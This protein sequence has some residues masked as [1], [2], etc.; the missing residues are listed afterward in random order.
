MNPLN[1]NINNRTQ[2]GFENLPP[3][4]TLVKTLLYEGYSLFP[5]HRSSIKNLKPIPMGVVYPATYEAYHPEAQAVMQ[6]ECIVTGPADMLLDVRVCFLHLQKKNLSGKKAGTDIFSPIDALQA[7]SRYYAT[8]WE[9]V[10]REIRCGKLPLSTLMNT[11]ITNDFEFPENNQAEMIKNEAGEVVGKME[12]CQF[13]LRGSVMVAVG[14]VEAVENCFKIT[15]RIINTT[16]IESPAFIGRDEVFN[17]SFLSTHFI[18]RTDVGEFVSAQ[19]PAEAFRTPVGACK[20]LHVY[21]VLVE[22]NNKTV[23]ASPMVLYDYPEI[24]PNSRG[25]LF[26]STEIEE[27][28]LLHLAVM[29]EEEKDRIAQTDE[30]LRTMIERAGMVTPEELLS[31]HGEMKM[32][33]DEK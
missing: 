29:S 18:L 27:A 22:K 19:D 17:Q 2:A 7:D 1:S 15:A 21:P 8:G 10:E 11:E 12:T 20:N 32:T 24:N 3:L 26:D 5:Y 25:D 4:D 6:A 30:K 13:P 23:L 9:A 31:L 33:D 16:G 14:K 28:L